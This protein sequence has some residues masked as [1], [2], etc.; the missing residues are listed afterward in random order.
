MTPGR[1]GF[2]QSALAQAALPGFPGKAQPWGP[3][4]AERRG[5]LKRTPL[6]WPSFSAGSRLMA[7]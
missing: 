3:R 4:R 7:R 6:R 1:R 2:L 5:I